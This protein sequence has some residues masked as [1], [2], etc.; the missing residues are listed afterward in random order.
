[1]PVTHNQWLTHTHAYEVTHS[2]P[3][4]TTESEHCLNFIPTIIITVACLPIVQRIARLAYVYYHKAMWIY[5]LRWQMRS[6]PPTQ[7]IGM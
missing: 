5:Q 3:S 4:Y 7:L 2:Q 1:V 6:Q